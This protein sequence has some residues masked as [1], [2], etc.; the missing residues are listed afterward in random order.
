M[1][2][3]NPPISKLNV[4]Q[5]K[6]NDRHC[7]GKCV[8]GQL[9]L[10]DDVIARRS[11]NTPQPMREGTQLKLTHIESGLNVNSN[12]LSFQFQF[13]LLL[14]QDPVIQLEWMK[15]GEFTLGD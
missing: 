7:W 8:D 1:N 4:D 14:F 11:M 3:V 13:E 2:V 6:W 5:M 12:Q 9:G 15:E 10:G